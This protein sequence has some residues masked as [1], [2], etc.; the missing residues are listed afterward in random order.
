MVTTS[1]LF[2]PK[3]G[4]ETQQE[5]LCTACFNEKYVVFEIPQVLEVRVCP[6]CP[7]YKVGEVWV[8]T[9]IGSYEEIAKKAAAKT[10]RLAM[11]INKEIRKP[12]VTITS[13]FFNPKILKSHIT[14]E[15]DVQDRHVKT[16]ADVE[17]RV[18][19]E[20]CEMC[21][22]MAG[23][24]YEA[25]LQIRG[26]GRLPTKKEIERCLKIADD[27]ISRAEKAGDRLAFVTDIQELPE[28]TDIYMGSTACS[29]QIARTIADEFGGTSHESPKLVGERDG[30]GVYRVT[31]AV[32]LPNIV[33]GDIVRMYGKP[34]VVEKLGKRVGGTDL[35]TGNTTSISSD[36]KLEK[37]SDRSKA[38]KTVLVSED[39]GSVQILDPI[40]YVPLTIKKP[41]FLNKQ[42]GDDVWVIKISD[43]VFLL[44]GGERGKE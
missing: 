12:K 43:G 33:Q 38:M 22:R 13:E 44:P 17:V 2:C 14:V 41:T 8:S 25:I 31:F 23:G 27:V 4:K 18:R 9:N 39:A 15:A 30:K 26:Q 24:Y 3:C 42:P 37:L 36:E 1:S 28:G 10:V 40:S 35:T 20:T 7:S 32:R 34:V 19:N 21:S 29:R 6:K 16:E 5:G 11:A